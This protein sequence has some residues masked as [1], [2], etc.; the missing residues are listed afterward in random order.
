MFKTLF[1]YAC[2][3]TVRLQRYTTKGAGLDVSCTRRY[4]RKLTKYLLLRYMRVQRSHFT[5]SW[6]TVD[7]RRGRLVFHT[8][9]PLPVRHP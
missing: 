9:S 4:H 5:Y 6:S 1:I 3:Y 8:A 7:H 2:S